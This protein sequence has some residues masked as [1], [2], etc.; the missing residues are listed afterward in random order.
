MGLRDRARSAF[1]SF[2]IATN[3]HQV[4][5]YRGIDIL[6]GQAERALGAQRI[7]A[8]WAWMLILLAVV[9]LSAAG[10][11]IA[12]RAAFQGIPETLIADLSDSNWWIVLNVTIAVL[13]CA[14][15]ASAHIGLRSWVCNLSSALL[16]SWSGLLLV[17]GLS[18]ER[19]VSLL[20]PT[21]GILFSVI[22]QVCAQKFYAQNVI[23]EAADQ[24]RQVSTET[25]E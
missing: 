12:N 11:D 21:F 20:G 14:A 22:A 4:K 10:L 13:L 24:A 1:L 6:S 19:G 2:G 15:A 3:P 18:V 9:H 17:A 25:E 8:S 7:W 23:Q 5:R 16:V